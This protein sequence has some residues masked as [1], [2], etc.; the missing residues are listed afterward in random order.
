MPQFIEQTTDGNTI[1]TNS[2][3]SPDARTNLAENDS[4]SQEEEESRRF[5]AEFTQY[6]G[7]RVP[8]PEL[9]EAVRLI[10]LKDKRIKELEDLTGANSNEQINSELYLPAKIAQKIHD[11]IDINR[12]VGIT[13][14]DF[15]L[16]HDGSQIL[17]VESLNGVNPNSAVNRTMH[18]EVND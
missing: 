15:I 6:L 16:R 9:I 17:A 2:G 8:S 11:I 7:G 10:S 4:F 12:T 3:G 18:D 1:T 14:I 13:E 5:H